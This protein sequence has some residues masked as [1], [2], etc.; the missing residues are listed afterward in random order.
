MSTQQKLLG[1]NFYALALQTEVQAVNGCTSREDARA[2]MSRTIDRLAIEISACKK[3]IG[4][5]TRLVVLPEY[6]L[7]AY[8]MGDT[9]ADWADKACL[10]MDGVEYERLGKIAQDNNL[11]L[12]GNAYEIDPHFEGLYFSN[13][14]YHCA[15]R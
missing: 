3:F 5:D 2:V 1:P 15:K 10:A 8:P 4:P 11:F 9:I 7:T 13:L 6:F 14:F 12:A